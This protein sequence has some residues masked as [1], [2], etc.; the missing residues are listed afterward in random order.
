[1]RR[2]IEEQEKIITRGKKVAIY[3]GEL[4]RLNV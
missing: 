3:T 2:Y 4:P 1:M